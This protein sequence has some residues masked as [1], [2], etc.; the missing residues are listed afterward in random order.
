MGTA[1]AAGRYGFIHAMCACV[2]TRGLLHVGYVMRC[3]WVVGDAQPGRFG[4]GSRPR[5]APVCPCDAGVGA[6]IAGGQAD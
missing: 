3:V 1:C 6:G 2:P 4:C 5:P